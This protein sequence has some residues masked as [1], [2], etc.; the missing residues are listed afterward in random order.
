[1]IPLISV[2]DTSHFS[3][4][5]NNKIVSGLFTNADIWHAII[6]GIIK[7]IFLFFVL[8]VNVKI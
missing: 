3:L 8:V 6:N 2:N 5:R 4:Y 7:I 1:M